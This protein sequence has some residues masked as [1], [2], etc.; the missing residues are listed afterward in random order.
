MDV[1]EAVRTVLAVRRFLPNAVPPEIVRAILE[2]GRLTASS[3]NR[4]PWHFVLVDDRPTLQALAGAAPT[5]P[6]IAE[7]GMALAVAI[8]RT[9]YA[10]SDA[11]RA[12]QSMVLSA[13]SQG[14]ASNWVGFFGLERA[15][16][17]LDIPA[18]IDL[19]AILAFGYPAS[20]SARGRKNRKPLSEI[21]HD[22]RFG[23]PFLR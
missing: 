11:S 1:V 19:L 4:Q 14:V 12:I 7:A 22:G 23:V 13:W 3:M 10:V 8:D 2:A 16:S 20:P 9:E 5:G 18:S 21:A 17:I 15:K 6:Y